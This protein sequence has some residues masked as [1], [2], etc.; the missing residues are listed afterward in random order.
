MFA[1]DPSLSL[2]IS[3]EQCLILDQGSQPSLTSSPSSWQAF[4]AVDVLPDYFLFYFLVLLTS[5]LQHAYS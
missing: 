2:N 3:Y 4:A 5:M 1:T